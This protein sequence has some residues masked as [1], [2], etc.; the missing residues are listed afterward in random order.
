[1]QHTLTTIA[2]NFALTSAIVMMGAAAHAATIVTWGADAPDFNSELTVDANSDTSSIESREVRLGRSP[3]QGI[4]VEETFTLDAIYVEVNDVV[5]FETDFQI[6]LSNATFDGGTDSLLADPADNLI[7]DATVTTPAAGDDPGDNVWV[8]FDIDN[9]T[10][11]ASSDPYA[12]Y[13][14]DQA[15]AN[16]T[17]IRVNRSGGNYLEFGANRYFEQRNSNARLDAPANGSRDLRFALVEVPE[18]ASFVLLGLAGAALGLRR[19]RG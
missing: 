5:Q 2:R 4:A 10:L 17:V 19:R 7:D 8:K 6:Y 13:L 14:W 3:A 11:T 12:L 18:P 15:V 1:M 9:I 16:S